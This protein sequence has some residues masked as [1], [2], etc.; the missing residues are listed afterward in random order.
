MNTGRTNTFDWRADLIASR[1]LSDSEKRGFE[2]IL[3]WFELWRV[4]K[5]LPVGRDAAAQFWREQVKSK[6]REAWQL[7]QWTEAIRWFLNWLAICERSG[8]DASTLQ[9]RVRHAVD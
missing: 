4:S 2:M 5:R 9:E 3:N 8:G 1:D 6:E 7:D